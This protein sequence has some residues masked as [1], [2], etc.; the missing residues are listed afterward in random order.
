[1]ISGS[2]SLLCSRF[3]SPFPHGTGSLSVSRK[4]LAL[5]DG[6]RWFTLNFSCSALLRCRLEVTADFGYGAF[7]RSGPPFQKVPLSFIT[8]LL[9]VL[10]PPQVR[11][12]T[13]GLGSCAFARHYLRNHFC[14]LFLRVLRC[15][16]S[17]GSLHAR[18]GDG[19]ASAGLP[20]SEIHGSTG[21]CPLPWLIAACHVLLRLQEPRHPSCALISFPYNV[22]FKTVSR[23]FVVGRTSLRL[24]DRSFRFTR[25][26]FS[27]IRPLHAPR[28][29]PLQYL[30][31][32]YVNV[33]SVGGE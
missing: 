32:Q 33:L 17:P 25:F 27:L 15:F 4:Y 23:F 21:I 10:Q 6:P 5:R 14:F 24:P 28:R 1:M 16:S 26:L 29:F 12:H 11:C 7:T 3:F 19:I 8:P 2:I 9:T 22:A 30:S 20:H 31:F 13:A 18:H